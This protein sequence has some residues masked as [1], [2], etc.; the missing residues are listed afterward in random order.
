MIKKWEWTAGVVLETSTG[1]WNAKVGVFF[2]G[3]DVIYSAVF[4]EYETFI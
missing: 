1:D 4:A 3:G 2:F